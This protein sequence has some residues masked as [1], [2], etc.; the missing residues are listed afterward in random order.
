MSCENTFLW[1]IF[2]LAMCNLK[3]SRMLV[4]SCENT[5]LWCILQMR[6]RLAV[7]MCNLKASKMRGVFSEGMI[8]CAKDGK[9]EILEP[10]P[11]VVPGDRVTCEGYTGKLQVLH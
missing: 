8:M 7:F 3:A 10:P 9:V 11:G 6:D 1:C 2:M 5:F 4:M